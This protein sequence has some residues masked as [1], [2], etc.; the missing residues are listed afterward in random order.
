MLMT[1][2]ENTI[3]GSSMFLVL[4]LY[5]LFASTFTL[6]KAALFYISPVL[7]IAIRMI[8][9]GFLLLGMQYVIRR[10]DMRFEWRDAGSFFNI[11]LF[12]IFI[13]FV[14]EFWALKYVT[15]T[16]A[17]LLYNMSPFITALLAYVL[18]KEQ[19]SMRKWLG[20]IIGFFGFLP[21]LL[22]EESGEEF[23]RHIG[24]LS[25]PELL[26]LVAVASSCYGWIIMKHLVVLRSYSPLMVNGISMLGG[27]IM[28]LIATFIVEKSPRIFIEQEPP[29]FSPIGYTASMIFI[30]IALLILI[31][32]VVC[33]NLYGI[34]LRRYSPTFIA[35]AGFTTPVFAAL[36]DF[37]FLGER[38]SWPFYVTMLFVFI[39]LWIFYKDE[40]RI[41]RRI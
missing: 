31:A 17:C 36:L 2:N 22:S 21:I 20:L 13:S 24:F 9:A 18:L 14:S 39:G 10:S 19:L 35:F 37:L 7:L 28:S 6:G 4:L 38:V 15:A 30:Y 12:L 27:G 16:K 41:I 34:L 1:G 3:D 33:F 23:M 32:N 8:A 25:I 11:T 29:F 26:L 5:F 40:L